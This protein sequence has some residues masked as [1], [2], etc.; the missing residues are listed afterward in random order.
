MPLHV[1]GT[2]ISEAVPTDASSMNTV[3]AITANTND[4]SISTLLRLG[5]LH[6]GN[7]RNIGLRAISLDCYLQLCGTSAF[8]A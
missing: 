2:L 6:R 1:S 3:A 8:A 5:F 4:F 7:R